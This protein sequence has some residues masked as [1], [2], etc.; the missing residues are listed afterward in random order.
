LETL[1]RGGIMTRAS[2]LRSQTF[3]LFALTLGLPAMAVSQGNSVNRAQ[4]GNRV[5]QVG[6]RVIVTLRSQQPGG[7]LRAP[8]APAVSPA[9]LR[10]LDGQLNARGMIRNTKRLELV[11]AVA[12]MVDDAQLDALLASP[13][14]ELVEPDELIQMQEGGPTVPLSLRAQTTPWGISRV[15][16]PEAW[17]IVGNGSG[18]KVGIIDSGGDIDHPDL[19]WA[20][21]YNAMTGSTSPSAWDD[22]ISACN[23]HGT[24]VA[25]TVAALNNTEGV[26]GVAPGVQIYALKV[27][28]VLNGDC[29]AWTSSQISAIT[30][31]V[32]QDIR[33][34]NVSIGGGTMLTSYSNAITNAAAQGT[35]L[36]GAAGNTGGSML[37]PGA[38]TDAIGI[39]ATTSSN[40]RAS[41]SSHGSAMD[42]AAPGSGIS[43]TM[44]GGGYGSKSGTSMAAPHATGVV[45]LLLAQNPSLTLEQLKDK[46][47]LGALDIGTAGW[48]E[49]TGWGLLQAVASLGGGT[50]PPPPPPDPLTLAVSP[51]SR[52]VSA[53]IGTAAASTSATVTLA[54]D[55]ASSTA[56][57]A[58]KRKTWTTLTVGSGTGSGNV[59]WSR[60]TTGLAVGTYVDT[61]TVTASGASG[62]PGRVI[63]TLVITAAPAPLTLAVSPGS[64]NISAQVGTAAA[65]A[66]ATVTLAGD[67]AATTAW[68][69]SK[70]KTW[71]TLT[72]GNGT[73]SGTVAWSRNTTGLAVGTYV[74]TITVTA[75]GATGSPSRVI[76]TLVITAAP[77]P[78][79]LAVS[80]GSRSISA[81]VGT[82]VSG[83]NATVTLAGD[84]AA[85]TAW[86][87]T[88]RRAWTTLT[89]GNGTGSGTVAWSR[90]TTGLAVGTYVDTITVTA[91]GATGSPARVIDTLVITAAPAPL[92]LAVSPGS[93]SVSAQQGT[94]VAGSN[95]TVSLTGDGAATTAWTATKR[96]AWTTLTTG[97]GTGSG[98]VAWSRNTTGLAVGTYVDTITVTAT[99]ATGSPSRVIDTLVITAAP[100][101]LTLA[102]S[103]GS[104]SISAQIGTAAAGSN[105]TITLS[106]TGAATTAWT[107]TKRRTWTTLT[108]ASG[109]GSG[110]VAWSRNTTGLAVGTYVDTITVTASG[111]TGSP[112]RVIDTLRI[113][114]APVPLTIAVSPGSRSVTA[115]QGTV[116]SG[117][118]ATVT[119][120]GDGAA[121]TA[122]TA[123]KRS[124][125]T[126]LTTSG[127]TGSGSV[128]WSRSTAGLVPGVY[129]DTITVTASGASGSPSRVIDTLRITSTPVPQSLAVSPGSRRGGTDQ[130][131]GT[132]LDEQVEVTISGDGAAAA[133][134]T[135]NSRRSW[136]ALAVTGGTGSGTLRWQR[137]PTGLSVG[138]HVDTISVALT[139]SSDA[140]AIVVDTFEIRQV[141][142]TVVITMDPGSRRTQKN[143]GNYTVQDSVY[144]DLSGSGATSTS[145]VVSKRADYTLINTAGGVGPRWM[146]W[147]RRLNGLTAGTYV[148]TLTVTGGATSADLIDTLVVVLPEEV[149]LGK[150]GGK[151]KVR[152]METGTTTSIEL[153]SVAVQSVSDGH[154][155]GVAWVAG[156]TAGWLTVSN[157]N[158]SGPGQLRFQ[159]QHG[160]L[161]NGVHVDSI[162]VA[163]A[164][165]PDVR[166]FYVD[167]VEVVTVPMPDP[168]VAANEL[169]RGSGTLSADQ[170]LALDDAGNG[171]GR[172]DLGDFLAWVRR[173]NIRL[174]PSVMLEV[175]QAMERESVE[176]GRKR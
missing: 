30:W 93:R 56:W 91:S 176:F 125:W 18:I 39:A 129:V 146:Y 130:G 106:G 175:Q 111:A 86:T 98:T 73:G 104:R 61:I 173:S 9:E 76:D 49:Y 83:S 92:T 126:T 134:W 152:R 20:G 132:V 52:N 155:D 99:G 154:Q 137:N 78:L 135:A 116:V 165:E 170:R 118:S 95:A 163:L 172:Y 63:D 124:A 115:Q 42:F 3:V 13:L 69:A 122:W 62:S 45:A 36:V 96:R 142:S 88:K 84:G 14:V 44:P 117:S 53:Q 133:S 127:G 120:A 169:F 114:A 21:G 148:D 68:T 12:G 50:P 4:L 108:T 158:G 66:N 48:D 60:N 82:A 15:Q 103:P 131:S 55:G 70:R 138:L 145:W 38:Y 5:A 72:T 162:V 123:T 46:L 77:V 47:Q 34:L 59:A 167:T 105:A 64:R 143:R 109:T 67:G 174:S 87:A 25:G 57:T 37:Y 136:N 121:T 65:G 1:S 33:V 35:F 71:T 31:A 29:L 17:G 150:G 11:G 153:D 74:D 110:T 166:A 8:G 112:S 159:R 160:A 141:T 90:S 156:S 22:N 40:V 54:G 94:A 24:H 144:V 147:S 107:A 140:P 16:A 101:P 151:T 113:T 79:T 2:R 7:A 102:V 80:P 10:D 164:T 75:T 19:D 139:G 128:A 85:T 51:G 149:V 81:Q 43:S 58:S 32:S 97:N 23:G 171:N 27:F 26:V 28:E 41:Y 89:S 161:G 6:G 168:A 157:A 100:V 119:L